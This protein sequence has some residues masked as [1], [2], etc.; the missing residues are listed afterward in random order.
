MPQDIN[1]QIHIIDYGSNCFK[2]Y[3]GL[4][5]K[6][7]SRDWENLTFSSLGYDK[8]FAAFVRLLYEFVT[9]GKTWDDVKDE[10][11]NIKNNK[12]LEIA[13]Y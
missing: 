2:H 6:V 5:S 3:C 1:Y 4:L 13:T 10:L 9:Q 12:T 8:V 11:T 7:F